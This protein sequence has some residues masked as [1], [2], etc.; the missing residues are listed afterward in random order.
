MITRLHELT[1]DE[2]ISLLCGDKTIIAPDGDDVTDAEIATT[3]RNIVFEYRDIA[4]SKGVRQFI[5]NAE[6]YTKAKIA[7][8]MFTMC[9][10][11]MQLHWIEQTRKLLKSCGYDFDNMSE[12]RLKAEI[13]SRLG[14]A[15]NTIKKI[16]EDNVK[17]EHKEIDIRREFDNQTAT[18]M[19]YFKFQIDTSTMKATIYA[20][21]VNR[22]DNEIRAQLDAVK[23][24]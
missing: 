2:F 18:L 8:T 12:K 24:R 20:N 16:D 21:L 4:D 6:E 14:R 17:T 23:K 7:L 9:N 1:M 15:R 5:S 13:Q 10:N 11:L 22:Y 3:I 19:A